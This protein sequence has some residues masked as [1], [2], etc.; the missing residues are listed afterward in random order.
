MIVLKRSTIFKKPGNDSQNE[1]NGLFYKVDN[2]NSI[3]SL[4]LSNS[5]IDN[6]FEGKK[7]ELELFICLDVS[8]SMAG[9]GITQAKQAILHLI[10][11]LIA[12]NSIEEKDITCMFF[13][14]TC[15][16]K[17][18][19]DD[20]NLLWDNG[21]IKEYFN[22]IN[23]YGGTNFISVFEKISENIKYVEKDLAIIFFTDG[24]N[25]VKINFDQMKKELHVGL[26]STGHATEIHTIGFTADHD[27]AL[28]SWLTNLGTKQGNFQYVKSS[29]DI[30][31]TMETTVGLLE[32]GERLLYVNIGPDKILPINIG[33]DGNG[34][35]ILKGE[36]SKLDETTPIYLL[37]E[38]SYLSNG[39]ESNNNNNNNKIRAPLKQIQP[40]EPIVT[41]LIITFI[42]SEITKLTDQIINLNVDNRR[43]LLDKISQQI[44]IHDEHLNNMMA[45]AYKIKTLGRK[46]TIQQCLETKSMVHHFKNLLAE[47]LKGTLTNEKIANFNNLAYNNITKNR[48]KK[49]MNDRAVKNIKTLEDIEKKIEDAVR[50]LDFKKLEDG[51]TEENLKTLTCALTTDNYIESLKCG[52]CM[53]LALD[54][55]RP[56][57]AIADPSKIRIKK[58][59]Q[60]FLSSE[61]F[62]T[63]VE[64][65]LGES[66]DS[67][68]VHGGFQ[69]NILGAN[70]V[71]GLANE[72]ITGIL[73]L[74]INEYHWSVAKEKIKPIMGYITTLDVFGYAYD[75][76]TTVPFLVL[77]KSLTDTSTDFHRKQFKLILDTCDAIYKQS[78]MLREQNKTL[79]E[80]YMKSPINRTI[81]QVANNLV[82][83]GH[84]LCAVRCG[85]VNKHDLNNWIQKG[86]FTYIIEETIR[87]RLNKYEKVEEMMNNVPKVLGINLKAFIDDPIDE[88]ERLYSEYDKKLRLTDNSENVK[89]KEAFKNALKIFKGATAVVDDDDQKSLEQDNNNKEIKDEVIAP[90][91]QTKLFDPDNHRLPEPATTLII[92]TIKQSTSDSLENILIYK[93]IFESLI[94]SELFIEEIITKPEFSFKSNQTPLTESFFDQYTSKTLLATFYQSF[95]HQQNSVRRQAIE[96]DPIKFFEP[97]SEKDSTT[98]LQTYFDEYVTETLNK[99]VVDVINKY[100]DLQNYKL[101]LTF[102]DIENVEE[103]AGLLLSDVKFRGSKMFGQII[104]ALQ[105]PNLK[106]V[107][108]KIQ[109]VVIGKWN[110]IV[111]FYDKSKKD[112][113]RKDPAWIPS[114]K[115]IHRTLKAQRKILPNME[116]WIKLFPTYKTYI[117]KQYDEE[118][119]KRKWLEGIEKMKKKKLEKSS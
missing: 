82:Y 45:N 55:T 51:E 85:D 9:S 7:R 17:R 60:S 35:I 95:L 20:P 3:L 21:K 47:A 26:S 106:L 59:N 48:L 116:Y 19:V 117:E 5:L 91:V 100:S 27:A 49:K 56:Q 71:K 44:S 58:I 87:R 65:A 73:P 32:L 108:E 53:C 36:S 118:Y 109:M 29:I 12:H 113:A 103:A 88:Y 62:L 34:T 42:Q 96:S 78:Q 4:K 41:S 77:A 30:Q 83:L 2:D 81:D 31:G 37:K 50:K 104:K 93:K 72:N 119:L 69:S 39:A 70:V 80:N 89:Y 10:E 43:E 67:E 97:F 14:S 111:L 68:S 86:M 66:I 24:Q 33:D 101:M 98:I 94:T 102:C 38:E 28:L 90:T 13:Q 22:T 18:F 46:L 114:K 23:A 52:E 61:A 63:S 84:L 64:Y 57:S 74:Y 8:G 107:D 15:D 79:F 92:G 25:N 54:V 76:V 115:N 1:V 6:W 110:D 16:V 112:G 75:Q 11:S 105:M 99:K 40:D